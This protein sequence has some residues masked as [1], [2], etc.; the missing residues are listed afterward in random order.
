[1]MSQPVQETK[2]F[3]ALRTSLGMAKVGIKKLNCRVK[4]VGIPMFF[5]IPFYIIII[6]YQNY[7][8]SDGYI[9]TFMESRP[10]SLAKLFKL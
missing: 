10:F 9:D 1:M 7:K 8:N 5:R 4:N 2:L 6:R 3:F